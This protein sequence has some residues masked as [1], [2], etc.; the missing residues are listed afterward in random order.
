[1]NGKFIFLTCLLLT[2]ALHAGERLFIH[3]NNHVSSGVSLSEMNEMYFSSDG[4]VINFSIGDQNFQ[5]ATADVDSLSFSESADTVFVRY[6]ETYA[7]I[8]NPLAFNGVSFEVN[9]ASVVIDA[10]EDA[11]NVCYKLSGKTTNGT[12]KLDS[13]KKFY[14]FLDGVTITNPNGP[15]VNIQSK[16]KAI[17]S[18]AAGTTNTFTDGASYSDS[19]VSSNGVTEEQDGAF[20][21]EGTLIFSGS[22]NLIINGKGSIQHGLCSD[23]SIQI[24]GGNITIASAA[25]DAINANEGIIISGGT[26]ELTATGDAIDGGDGSVTILGGSITTQNAS[27]NVAGITC[28]STIAITG[29]ILNMT[30][31]GDQ[32]KGLKAEKAIHLS[33]GNLTINTS[34]DV[35]LEA[36]GTGYDPSYCTAIKCDSN[37][38]I[39]G[40][41]I[42][43][44]SSGDGGKGISS[45]LDLNI[46][47]GT[48]K[49]TTT[50]D[51]ATYTNA[52]GSSDTYNATG[53]TADGN[54]NIAGG[55]VTLSS[56]GTAGKGLTADGTL[57]IGET[58]QGPIINIITSGASLSTSGG[59]GTTGPG[60]GG[61]TGPG[62]GG[63]RRI[64]PGTSSQGAEAKAISCD[65]AITVNNGSVTISS[66]DDGIKSE[67]SITIKNGTVSII[68]SIEG[69]EAPAITVSD[70]DVQIAASDDGFNAT[71][72]NGGESNDGSKLYLYGGNIAV[73]V[74]T[75][76]G[77]DSNGDIVM[78]SG[79][80]V[81]HGPSSNPEVGMDY[82]G[83]FNISGGLL[84]ATGPN[85]GNMIEAT[86]T[87]SAQYAIKA[88]T[89]SMLRSSTLFHIE[90]AN[91]NCLVTFKPV[92]D[93]YYVV[94]SSPDLKSNTTYSIFTGGASTGTDVNGLYV[95]GTYSG[96]TLEKTFTITSKVT[97]VSF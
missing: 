5:Y 71:N 8:I 44:T 33:G 55:T 84:L 65:G 18:L 67:T 24:T 74:T 39:A 93:V 50:G 97:N 83:T 23:E 4:S 72:G 41:D 53:M 42:T 36:S 62:G 11:G 78:T 48:V 7:S 10:K 75:G 86:S 27:V 38:V 9:G 30:V 51:G 56:S 26:I 85:S 25:K 57:T 89:Y 28:D 88:T 58:N 73:N 52:T 69:M 34:G 94:F 79:T 64:D 61:T 16:K 12:F 35:A 70:G 66:A 20:Y 21:S 40:A 13:E 19:V 68:K 22:G 3:Q 59:G 87:S 92:R 15:A 60:G 31:G 32:S 43:I 2:T 54:I 90:D 63:G 17:I 14:L 80:V 6:N 82:N 29:G 49:I 77:L 76:D 45:D 1:M 91:G 96:G 95:G 46:L 37:I 81:V 47:S